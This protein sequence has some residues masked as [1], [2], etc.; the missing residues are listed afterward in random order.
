MNEYRPSFERFVQ[1]PRKFVAVARR[2]PGVH[3]HKPINTL[4]RVIRRCLDQ[5]GKIL[6]P[7]VT[8]QV[9]SSQS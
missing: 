8:I 2:N 7:P 9:D 5:R 1:S 3:Q 4:R 6:V